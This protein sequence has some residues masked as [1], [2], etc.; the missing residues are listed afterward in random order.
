MNYIEINKF[1]YMNTIGGSLMKNSEYISK[2]VLVQLA[3]TGVTQ[4]ELASKIGV[5]YSFF[6]SL[7]N[8]KTSDWNIDLMDKVAN[9]LGIGDAFS[10]TERAE[11]ERNL[12]VEK[13]A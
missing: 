11:Y 8:G 2:A 3:R 6:N 1:R 5:S 7:I 4:S 13:V 9:A 12:D 10:L